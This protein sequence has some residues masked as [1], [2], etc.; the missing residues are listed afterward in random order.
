MFTGGCQVR[1]LEMSESVDYYTWA[2]IND[3]MKSKQTTSLSYVAG[4]SQS[5]FGEDHYQNHGDDHQSDIGKSGSIYM[6]GADV[7]TFFSSMPYQNF[8]FSVM[9]RFSIG[10]STALNM[11]VPNGRASTN[12]NCIDFR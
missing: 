1:D 2:G 9:L 4:K 8:T 6:P 5:Y 7:I 10:E 12:D 3:V 11:S